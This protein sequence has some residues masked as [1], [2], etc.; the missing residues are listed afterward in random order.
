[1]IVVGDE[2]D[3]QVVAGSA[4][5]LLQSREARFLS[6]ALNPGDLRLRDLRPLGECPLAQL[7]LCPSLPNQ[8]PYRHAPMIA[9][10]SLRRTELL[11]PF[12]SQGKGSAANPYY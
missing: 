4:Q 10:T 7:R 3:L 8:R 11:P 5:E 6:P 9:D 2:L 1:M 12:A